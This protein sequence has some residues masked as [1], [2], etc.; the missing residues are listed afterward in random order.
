MAMW[1]QEWIDPNEI[2]VYH[3]L[4]NRQLNPDYIESL[5]ESM[6]IKGF[7][8]EFA[9]DV[10]MADSIENIKTDKPFICACGAHRTTAAVQAE[11]GKVLVNIHNGK[12]EAFVEMMHFDNFKFDPTVNSGVGQPF[13]QKEKRAAVMQLLLLPKFL[14]RTDTSLEEEFRIPASSIRRWRKEVV[15]LLENDDPKLQETWRISDGRIKRLKEVSQS[16]ERED[17]DGNTVA[18]R[19]PIAEATMD[20][21][22][23]FFEKM[24]DDSISPGATHNFEWDHVREWIHQKYKTEESRWYLYR[25]LSMQQM[26]KVHELLISEEPGFIKEIVRIAEEERRITGSQKRLQS[27]NSDLLK[28]F[29]KVFAPKESEYSK[30]FKEMRTRF[31]DFVK[32]THPDF[33]IEYWDHERKNRDNPDFCEMHSGIY[34]YVAEA[35]SNEEDEWIKDFREKE[36]KRMQRNRQSALNKWT[37]FRDAAILAINNYPRNIEASRILAVADKQ[38][39]WGKGLIM[40]IHELKEPISKNTE[41]IIEEYK[42][43]QKLAI[44][45]ND[46]AG[47]VAEIPEPTPL[48]ETLSEH[49][50]IRKTRI[51]ELTVIFN[52][53]LF[54]FTN[55]AHEVRELNKATGDNYH[56]SELSQELLDMLSEAIDPLFKNRMASPNGEGGGVE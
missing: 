8:P 54:F 21:K 47:W 5:S 35:L 19:Q 2:Y 55:D 56:F 27:S 23:A 49:A 28:I 26:Q 11:L 20:E 32:K 10:F 31:N 33:E 1:Q 38:L 4:N 52:G 50:G 13:T 3:E 46:D 45:V 16:N 41:T 6:Q 25:E 34:I 29:K 24:E 36:I 17:G 51:E 30:P 43:F 37:K 22:Q 12:E 18:V 42:L 14:K 48:I 39:D 40:R 9:I 53:E 15:K 44:A 7:L